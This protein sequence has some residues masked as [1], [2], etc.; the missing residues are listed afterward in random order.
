MKIPAAFIFDLDGVIVE[1]AHYHYKAWKRLADTLDIPFGK[2]ENQKLKGLSREKSMKEIL[3]L[4][5]RELSQ[6]KFQ[7]L[8]DRKNEWYQEYISNLTP[9][10]ILE[11]IPEFLGQ[12]KSMNVKLAIGSSSKNAQYIL[13]HLQLND[14]FEAVIDGTKVKNSKPDPEVFLKAA[15]ALE[16]DPEACLVFE[17][18]ASGIQAA[19][20][21]GM[22][23]VGV[24]SAEYLSEADLVIS[25]FKGL[26]PMRLLQQLNQ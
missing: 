3:A 10:D 5:D 9:E 26:T 24:G 22:I 2:S 6:E 15:K 18:A 21:G 4:D 12:L 16:V 17:D 20:A 11:G 7:S 19:R 25:S 1:T 13:D 14:S 8:M 23:C